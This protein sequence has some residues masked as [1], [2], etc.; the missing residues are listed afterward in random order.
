[1]KVGLLTPLILFVLI[2]PGCAPKTSPADAEALVENVCTRCHSIAVVKSHNDDKAGWRNVVKR[3]KEHGAQVD[4]ADE[5]AIVDYL[6]ETQP[7][8]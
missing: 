6:T 1:M 8:K 3:M 4:S 7:K 5:S 2:L